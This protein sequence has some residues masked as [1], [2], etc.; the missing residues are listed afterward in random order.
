MCDKVEKARIILKRSDS[1]ESLFSEDEDELSVLSDLSDDE[2]ESLEMGPVQQ[3]SLVMITIQTL[4]HKL[5]SGVWKDKKF[6]YGEVRHIDAPRDLGGLVP[7]LQ[8]KP[9]GQ[10]TSE[11]QQTFTTFVST[12]PTI[13]A[14]ITADLEKQL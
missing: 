3:A 8:M 11:E 9:W 1:L 7:N 5:Q 14:E 13:I 10:L 4:R 6:N 2:N 12:V